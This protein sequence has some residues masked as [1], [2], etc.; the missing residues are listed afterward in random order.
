M[1]PASIKVLMGAV[2][3][4]CLSLLMFH[5]KKML[6]NSDFNFANILFRAK[7]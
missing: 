6:S 2:V 1:S 7:F 5:I 3:F 4:N